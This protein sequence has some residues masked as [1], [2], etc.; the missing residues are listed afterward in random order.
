[1]SIEENL[2]ILYYSVRDEGRNLSKDEVICLS[3][4]ALKEYDE[5]VF[6]KAIFCLAFGSNY[7]ENNPKRLNEILDWELDDYDLGQV[8][9]AI[10]Y[11]ELIK[12]HIELLFEYIN[13][14]RF[15]S[16][17]D[18]SSTSA[19]N[20][21]SYY[22]YN[23]DKEELYFRL[24]KEF[25]KF[26]KTLNPEDLSEDEESFFNFFYK[27]LLYSKYGK[28]SLQMPFKATEILNS[29]LVFNI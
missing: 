20:T 19:L 15:T 24:H 18:C 25:L 27:A 3:E 29:D 1:M 26:I 23:S 6:S 7:F 12:H 11:S 21:I 14:E 2:K 22:I 28:E 5:D 8:F 13:F 4:E 16:D 10:K 17:W 9:D